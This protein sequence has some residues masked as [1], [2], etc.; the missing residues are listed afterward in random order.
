M[1]ESLRSVSLTRTGPESFEATN[2]RGGTLHLSSGGADSTDFTP[3]ELLL[4]GVAGCSGIDVDLLTSRLSQPDS[5]TISAEADKVRDENGSH[6]GPL[7]VTVSVTFPDGE[8]GDAARTRLPDAVAK[9]RD[10]LCTVSRTV[11][12]PTPVHYE[13]VEG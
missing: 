1:S 7:T 3:V 9:S 11:L 8:G 4:A 12:L 10:R 13:I 6:L 5:F 2:A